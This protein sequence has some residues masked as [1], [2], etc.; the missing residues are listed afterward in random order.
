MSLFSAMDAADIPIAD[1]S[2]A[3]SGEA[4]AS[5]LAHTAGANAPTAPPFT[6]SP[7]KYAMASEIAILK[8]E[9]IY[10]RNAAY[11]TIH[12]QR[13]GF[14]DAAKHFENQAR[15]NANAERAQA[16]ARTEYLA[17]P[18]FS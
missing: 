17:N 13:Q 7:R 11:A 16:V 4:N 15:D 14:E 2:A 3:D 5:A 10:Q 18:E 1:A 12:Q 6:Q 9:F 8:D